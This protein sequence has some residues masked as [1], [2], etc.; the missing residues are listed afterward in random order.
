ML[1]SN[2]PELTRLREEAGHTQ[3]SLG[4]ES[5]VAQS[6]ISKLERNVL[7]IRPT[8]AKRLADAIGAKVTDIT[9]SVAAEEVAS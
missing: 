7:E 5:G 8:T 3:A 6:H 4:R 1:L 9:T 2:P